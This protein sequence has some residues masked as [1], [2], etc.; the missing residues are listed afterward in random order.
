MLESRARARGGDAPATKRTHRVAT[1]TKAGKGA[2]AKVARIYETLREDILSMRLA[3]GSFLDEIRIADRF[4]V[5][6]S[7]VR[8]AL[9]RLN[10][11][12]FVSTHRNRA[13]IVT[14]MD[15][16]SLPHYMDALTLVQRAVTRLAAV[17]RTDKDLEAIR[18]KQRVFEEKRVACDA[19]AM[20]DANRELHLAIADAAA[21]PYLA[22][23]YARLL[24]D[25]RRILRVFFRFFKD[26]LPPRYSREHNRIIRAIERQDPVEAERLAGLH[27]RHVSD[28]FTK[29]IREGWTDSVD[30]RLASLGR[31]PGHG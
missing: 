25:G 16:G 1:P 28:Q 4:K 31:A 29:S 5:S 27:A 7:P 12:G 14:P 11:D 10:A 17:N 24:D 18:E 20:I 8:E 22:M 2:P 6:R 26:E 21:N 15:M 30:V 9:I 13:A 19:P 23:I 3:P